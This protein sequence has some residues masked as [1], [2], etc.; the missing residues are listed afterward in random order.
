MS[1]SSQLKELKELQPRVLHQRRVLQLSLIK[2]RQLHKIQVMN[3]KKR[4]RDLYPSQINMLTMKLDPFYST[5]RVI[6]SF[7]LIVTSQLKQDRDLSKKRR[8]WLSKGRRKEN[9]LS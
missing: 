3:L 6:D 9:R 4:T 1:Q 8:P 2:R 7:T 5:T